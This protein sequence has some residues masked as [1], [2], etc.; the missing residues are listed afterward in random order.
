MAGCRLY[1]DALDGLSEL[2]G[3][4][5]LGLAHTAAHCFLNLSLGLCSPYCDMKSTA[6]GARYTAG[7][8]GRTGDQTLLQVSGSAGY[9]GTQSSSHP[10]PLSSKWGCSRRHVCRSSSLSS[11]LSICTSHP[12]ESRGVWTPQCAAN[13]I[14]PR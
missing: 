14:V 6:V 1:V 5:R 2:D 11:H 8:Q 3:P 9:R 13:Y 10:L 4:F 12:S 7:R